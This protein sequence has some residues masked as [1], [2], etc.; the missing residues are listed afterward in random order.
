MN[1][2]EQATEEYPILKNHD[3]KYKE[4]Y[5]RGK[6]FLEFWPADETGSPELPRPEEFGQDNFGVE[7]YDPKTRPIDVVGDI[8][9]HH[10]VNVDPKI[11]KHY[12]DFSNSLE[13][14]QID[15]L[16][17]Q[18]LYAQEN[19]GENRP[20]KNW[21][22]H[23][24]LPGY[25]RGYAFKQWEKPEEM[26]TKDQ[27]KNFDIMTNYLKGNNQPSYRLVPVTGNPFQ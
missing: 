12:E 14:W 5:G 19:Y 23:S 6:G 25:F 2:L 21:K 27:M 11:K 8:V 26:Y 9:S 3:V 20:F 16:K 7:I 13:P 10:L 1:L 17:N 22:E 24:G 18:Y 15:N 4:S